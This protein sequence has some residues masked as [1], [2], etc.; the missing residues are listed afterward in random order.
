VDSRP[1][2]V[3]VTASSALRS[4]VIPMAGLPRHVPALLA[5]R[6][7]IAVYNLHFNDAATA[8]VAL[9]LL[10]AAAKRVAPMDRSLRQGVWTPPDAPGRVQLLAG[11]TA[12]VLG[13]GAIGR[14]VARALAALEVRVIATRGTPGPVAVDGVAEVH[15]AADTSVLLPQAEILMICLPLTPDTEGLLGE[16]ELSRLPE[17][18]LLVN[19]GRGPVVDEAALF[20]A[21]R[22]G[23][24][25]AAGIDVWYRYPDDYPASSAVTAPSA[26][27]FESL[28]NVVMSPHRAGNWIAQEN[29]RSRMEALAVTLN[30]LASGSDAPNR[31]DLARGY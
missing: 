20:E 29:E 1:S 11:K 30:A 14:R 27:P 19:V 24:L 12:L 31:V 17:G 28:D 8:E 2:T 3:L 15:P 6:P 21:L 10:L 22:S 23:R 7:E 18:A 16:A 25:G 26:F 13:Y 9:A 5:G 4:L